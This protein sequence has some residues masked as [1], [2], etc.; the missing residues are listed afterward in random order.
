MRQAIEI[1]DITI[2]DIAGADMAGIAARYDAQDGQAPVVTAIP[3]VDSPATGWI[4][5][6]SVVGSKLLA[7]ITTHDVGFAEQV[8]AGLFANIKAAFFRPNATS[9]PTRGTPYLKHVTFTNG[10]DMILEQPVFANSAQESV[11]FSY[12][13]N[14]DDHNNS[15]V[16]PTGFE[17]QSDAMDL[18]HQSLNLAR[19]ENIDFVD[20]AIRI[21]E[22]Q[23][24]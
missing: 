19:L 21:E 16:A 14:E 9:N 3:A 10:S 4:T 12:G 8:E 15:F 24:H 20:A 17:V 18:Y 23:H 13:N 6:L 5:R 2:A 11:C 7:D 22:A 1:S